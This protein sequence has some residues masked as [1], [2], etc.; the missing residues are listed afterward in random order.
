MFKGASG[1][2]KTPIKI[3]RG[4]IYSVDFQ[5][6][7][8]LYKKILKYNLA[9]FSVLSKEGDTSPA[10]IS[11]KQKLIQYLVE[12]GKKG[13]AIQRYKGLGE[14]NPEQLWETTMNPETRI[15]LQV[16]VENIVDTDDIF[17]VLM[18]DEVEPRRN[19]IQTNALDVSV[20]DI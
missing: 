12:E 19:F 20:L 3:G 11:D 9:P 6:A 2:N 5:K 10:S 1:K 16:K 7:L 4:L 14:M 15:L 17:S 18:G 13:L 8:M